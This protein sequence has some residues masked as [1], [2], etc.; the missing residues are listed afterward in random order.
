MKLRTLFVC[1]LFV[2]MLTAAQDDVLR[3]NVD[4]AAFKYDRET[5]YVEMYYSF[6]RTAL[7]YSQENGMFTAAAVVHTIIRRED[8]DADPVLKNWRVPVS[9]RDTA[10][11]AE[12]AL[13]GRVNYL[14]EPGRYNIAVITRDEARPQVSDS[15]QLRFEVRDFSKKAL[16][17][18]DIEL[19][20]SIQK[21]EEDASNIFYKNTLEI[22]PNPTLLY[23]KPLPNV[24]Y[25]AELYHA[26]DEL[27]YIKSEIVSSYGK[28]MV[29]K[30]RE[31]QGRHDSRVEVGSLN[32]STLPSGVYTL[33][34]SYG[35]TSGTFRESQSKPFFVFNPDI[36]LDTLEAA[37]IADMIAAEFSA[38]SES[39]LDEQFA[40]ARYVST[41][42][43]EDI[44]SSL[45]GTEPKKKFLTKFWR[46]RDSD[47]MTPVNEFYQEYRQRV[48]VTNEQFR[49][50]FRDGWRSDR[51]RVYIMY[52]P[53]DYVERLSSESDMKPH[54]IWR[55][56][57][58]E[59]GVEFVFV[60][61]GGFNNYEL[62]HSTKRNEVSNPDWER[63]A[64]TY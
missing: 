26:E 5:S 4:L 25:Y 31:R 51:G 35:D 9:V 14:L 48:A 63:S 64:S 12:K 10:G 16:R 23:G 7:V 20:S 54:E 19:A 8:E 49:S 30:A 37:E 18:S 56:D 40:I 50:A 1:L 42:E 13:I 53:P 39:E 28:T 52:G 27:F 45:S 47:V 59:G 6:P 58:I 57:Y 11:M 22:V 15:V 36:P 21:A 60:D 43:E 33:I 32:L 44:W 62:V 29:S 61:K 34:L 3:M 17:F 55:Y 24:L 38:M 2:P 41:R 46:S